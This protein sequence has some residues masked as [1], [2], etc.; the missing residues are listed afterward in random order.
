MIALPSLQDALTTL[1]FHNKTL[2]GTFDAELLADIEGEAARR[3]LA[4]IAPP[5][6]AG[7][8]LLSFPISHPLHL[9]GLLLNA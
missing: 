6:A 7:V 9:H 1:R 3:M 2:P 8:I 5:D 4:L